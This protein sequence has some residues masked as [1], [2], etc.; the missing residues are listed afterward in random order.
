MH[1]S[2]LEDLAIAVLIPCYNEAQT[3]GDVVSRLPRGAAAAPHLCL[4][5]QFHATDTALAPA[6]A[7]ATVFR[8]PRQGKGNVVRRMFADIEADI[9]LMADGD[10]TYAPDDAPQLINTL[11]TERSDMV[12]GTRPRRDDDAGRAGPCLR[13]PASSTGSTSASSAGF[14]RHLFRLPRLHAGVSSRAFRRFPMASRSRRKCRSMPRS[15]KL[16]VSEIAARLT[17][18]GRRVRRPSCRTFDD[19]AKILWMFALPGEG[20][21]AASLSSARLRAV[22]GLAVALLGVPVADRILRHR[23]RAAAA[24]LGASVSACVLMSMLIAFFSGLMLDAYHPTAAAEMTSSR[25]SL[26]YPPCQAPARTGKRSSRLTEP[27]RIAA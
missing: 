8:E 5:Q 27:G 21:A 25:L 16:P 9:Y 10:G 13:Q 15:C 22:P 23:A 4:R 6:Q 20:D 11:L 18:A 12:V 14:H 19:G 24:D 17:A 3:I 7:G 1:H 2:S 26:R